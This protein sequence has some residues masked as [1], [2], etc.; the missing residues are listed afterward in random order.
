[1]AFP[2]VASATSSSSGSV[3][4][5]SGLAVGDLLL[6]YI[7]V[8]SNSSAANASAPDGTWTLLKLANISTSFQMAS[9]WKL[10]TSADVAASNFAFGSGGQT[11]AV[12]NRIT[13]DYPLI[14]VIVS[15][16]GTTGTTTSLLSA[17]IT[18][19]IQSLFVIFAGTCTSSNN[20][21]TSFTVAVA[22]SNPSWNAGATINGSTS[23]VAGVAATYYA[24][25]TGAPNSATGNATATANLTPTVGDLQIIAIQPAITVPD[26]F[27]SV[28]G[29]FTVT[30]PTIIGALFG[31]TFTMLQATASEITNDWTFSSK[32]STSSSDWTNTP[33]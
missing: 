18:P 5:P 2:V 32:G 8:N 4:K 21:P 3:G 9:Y 14:P 24:N 25:Q 22:N 17:G 23:P 19:V 27:G 13:S 7:V 12:L 33:K 28:F 1:M 20:T 15:N 10:A 11:Y 6:A 16:H 31:A 30:V 26:I 29:L